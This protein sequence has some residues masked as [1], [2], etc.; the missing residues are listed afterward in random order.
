[1]SWLRGV[2][3]GCVLT[4]LAVHAPRAAAQA[5]PPSALEIARSQELMRYSLRRERLL[6][7]NRNYTLPAITLGLGV[8]S[9]VVGGVVFARAWHTANLDC[10][11]SWES[12]G[13][14]EGGDY[15]RTEDRAGL[16]MMPLGAVLIL[17]S[18]PLL[19]VRLSRQMRLQRTERY[20]EQLARWTGPLTLQAPARHSLGVTTHWRF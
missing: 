3:L 10:D 6:G 5:A 9:L 12:H 11:A 8:A 16:V 7:A 14:A 2:L 19:I 4:S 15:N 1:M 17:V 20:L 18:T 13:C